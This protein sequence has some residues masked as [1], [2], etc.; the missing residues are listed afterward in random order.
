MKTKQL[1]YITL[2]LAIVTSFFLGR[3]SVEIKTTNLLPK[4]HLADSSIVNDNSYLFDGTNYLINE[5]ITDKVYR[6]GNSMIYH[7]TLKHASFKRC[8]SKVSKL[9]VENAKNLGMR[10]CK[11][12]D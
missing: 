1:K 5:D 10:H 7:P 9:T 2:S 4:Q 3:E 11:C 6:C 12:V 8:K